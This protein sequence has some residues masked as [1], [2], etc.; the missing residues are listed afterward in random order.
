MIKEILMRNPILTIEYLEENKNEIFSIIPEL[1]D[2]EGFDQKSAWHIYDVW[3]HTEVALTNSN[4]DF[5]ERLALLLHD[6]G[7]PHC[8][9]DDGDIRHFKGH[10]QKS[11]EISRGILKRLLNDAEQ[12]N[13]IIYLIENHSSIIDINKVNQNNIE[14]IKKLLD[15][16]YC[17][18]RAYNPEKIEPALKRLDG[19]RESL[20]DFSK[21]AEKNDNE[22]R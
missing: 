14:L 10:A 7:K 15:I 4:Q 6:I 9:Q 22:E 12:I 19:I 18:T 17:D 8:Y 3:T 1:K 13:R 16:Q 20:K 2:E 21:K 11:A 5:E